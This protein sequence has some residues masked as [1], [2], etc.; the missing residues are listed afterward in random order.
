ML[1]TTELV[2]KLKKQLDSEA[3]VLLAKLMKKGMDSNAFI[4]EEVKKGLIAV[5]INCSEGKIVPI[6]LSMNNTKSNPG[7]LNLLICY[8]AL[9]KK[10]VNRFSTLKDCDKLLVSLVTFMFDSAN[11][12]RT[13]AKSVFFQLIGESLDRSEIDRILIRSLNDQLYQK[14]QLVID[15]EFKNIKAGGII[16][17]AMNANLYSS[18]K[19]PIMMNPYNKLKK[20]TTPEN[21]RTIE[22]YG[23]NAMEINNYLKPNFSEKESLKTF[24]SIKNTTNNNKMIVTMSKKLKSNFDMEGLNKMINQAVSQ[25]WK[26]RL[27]A[28]KD[29]TDFVEKNCEDLLKSKQANNF[30]DTYLK[31]IGDSN[32]KVALQA[33]QNFKDLI[34]NIKSL[35]EANLQNVLNGIFGVLGSFN[36]GLRSSAGELMQELMECFEKTL[37]VQGLCNG[38]MYAVSKA[39]S[40]I[41]IKLLGK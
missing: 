9:I 41:L 40:M 22:D 31:L 36:A 39:R 17:G 20:S 8:E 30:L 18:I 27:E 23:V 26:T 32:A 11:E 6:L 10:C 25:D 15:K 38:V 33:I 28:L 21:T 13:L 12:V 7:K 19:K 37:F 4:A 35:I 16:G 1:A 2:E 24:K 34:I 29:L 3:D 5:S 14:V